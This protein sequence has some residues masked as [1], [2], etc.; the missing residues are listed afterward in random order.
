MEFK[1]QVLFDKVNAIGELS[2]L[3]PGRNCMAVS[4]KEEKIDISIVI[5]VSN[6][7]ENILPLAR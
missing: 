2:H 7:A 4:I 5:P 1:Q 6:E 3:E